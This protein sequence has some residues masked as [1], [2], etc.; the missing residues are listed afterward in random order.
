MANKARK[1]FKA[2]AAKLVIEGKQSEPEAPKGLVIG[3]STMIILSQVMKT[4]V[5]ASWR[6]TC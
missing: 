1:I 5:K 3:E 2:A 6:M 4:T